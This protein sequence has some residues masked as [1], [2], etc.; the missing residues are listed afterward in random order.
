MRSVS[1]IFVSGNKWSGEIPYDAP[2]LANVT[3]YIVAFDL[4]DKGVK[5][6]TYQY[7]VT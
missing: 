7:E 6:D 1:M 2:Y 5:S 3:Y 4:A